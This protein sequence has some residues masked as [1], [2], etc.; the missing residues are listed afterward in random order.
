MTLKKLKL[1]LV[2]L[3]IAWTGCDKKETP[4]EVISEPEIKTSADW[5]VP[6]LPLLDPAVES[7]FNPLSV[8]EIHLAFSESEWNSMLHD[9][10]HN[11]RNEMYRM[12]SCTVSGNGINLSFPAV[13]V[14]LRGNT[15]R[16]RPEIGTGNHLPENKLVRVH[17]KIKFNHTFDKDEAAYG[18]PSVDIPKNTAY[19]TQQLFTNVSSLN[20]KYNRDDPTYIREAVSYDI[21][22]KFGIEVVKSTFGKLYIKIGNEAERY[23]G[24]YFA[25]EDIDKTWIRKRFNGLESTLF[26]CLWQDYGPADLATPDNDGSLLTGR[27]GEELTD[28][29]SNAIFTSGFR[30]YHPSYD[31]KEDPDATGVNAINSLMNLLI[32]N[33]TKEQLEAAID[34]QSLLRA[35]AVNVMI[36]MSDDY[37]RG[38]NNYYMYR[39]PLK[40]NRW[41]FLPYDNDRSFGINTFGSETSTSSVLNWGVNSGTKCNPVLIN[42]I[43]AI[44][45]FKEDYRAYLKYLVDQNYFT[46]ATVISRMKEMQAVISPFISGYDIG[47]DAFPYSGDFSA[48]TNYVKSRIEVVSKECRY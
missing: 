20:L 38:G 41:S 28:P 31:L 7:F 9:Y 4:I 24:V 18:A 15:S 11:K 35:F 44:P 45:Q 5:A 36:G 25:F 26:K 8:I 43:L 40:N 2:F 48:I 21:Y 42:R 10:D 22:R 32:G 27:I 1:F 30:A 17:Y 39:N 46:E 33:P 19:K 47:T 34:V 23:L 6:Q 37:W 29:A 12:A 3:L 16:T 13:A 14:R